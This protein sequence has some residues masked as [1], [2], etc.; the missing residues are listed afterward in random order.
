MAVRKGPWEERM[1]KLRI[2]NTGRTVVLL[3]VCLG[4][5]LFGFV[6]GHVGPVT[7]RAAKALAMRQSSE[8]AIDVSQRSD[9][10]LEFGNLS[11]KHAK[12][13]PNRRFTV[14]SLGM[15]GVDQGDWLENLR[16]TL[17]NKSNKRVT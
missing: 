5:T 4:A 14:D 9:E 1:A 17:M 7:A 11:V 6:L 3:G 8:K 16:F 15:N 13:V 10:P 2:T 12:I